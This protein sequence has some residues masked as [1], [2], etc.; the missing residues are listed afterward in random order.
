M[1]RNN[2]QNTKYVSH[3]GH[4]SKKKILTGLLVTSNNAVQVR[5]WLFHLNQI[6]FYH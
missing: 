3:I 5:T 4:K 1:L 6:S 2:V